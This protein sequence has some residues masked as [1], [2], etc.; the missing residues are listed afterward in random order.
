MTLACVRLTNNKQTNP[1]QHITHPNLSA[2]RECTVSLSPN[3]SPRVLPIALVCMRTAPTVSIA[4]SE[5]SFISISD[6]I[7][8]KSEYLLGRVFGDIR[9]CDLVTGGVTRA[10]L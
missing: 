10:G 8:L 7:L 4:G 1:K 9:R 2:W 3:R 6:F 5:E